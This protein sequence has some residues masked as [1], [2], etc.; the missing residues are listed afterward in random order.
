MRFIHVR[1]SRTRTGACVKKVRI[2]TSSSR[3]AGAV[4]LQS[5]SLVWVRAGK[6]FRSAFRWSKHLAEMKGKY[7]IEY[8]PKF[9]HRIHVTSHRV[10]VMVVWKDQGCL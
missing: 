2:Y 9:T 7:H 4:A 8:T 6:K 5:F 10:V 1:L 3:H